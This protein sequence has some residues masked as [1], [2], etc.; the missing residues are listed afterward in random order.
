MKYAIMKPFD[1]DNSWNMDMCVCIYIYVCVCVCVLEADIT[2]ERNRK[3][4][5]MRHETTKN[6]GL[7]C[8][9]RGRGE[10]NDNIEKNI[11]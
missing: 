7:L 11:Q 6:V 10:K 1:I 9:R 5:Q 4:E 3:G 2:A 8:G